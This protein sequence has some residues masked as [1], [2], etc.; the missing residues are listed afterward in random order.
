MTTSRKEPWERLGEIA[1]D[2]WH[3]P[4]MI[5]N[6]VVRSFRENSE[7]MGLSSD[8]RWRIRPDFAKQ[9]RKNSLRKLRCKGASSPCGANFE[10]AEI[11]KRAALGARAQSPLPTQAPSRPRA[12]RMPVASAEAPHDC[13][14]QDRRRRANCAVSH[15]R[16]SGTLTRSYRLHS[17]QATESSHS[18]APRASA[19]E[20]TDAAAQS[21]RAVLETRTGRPDSARACKICRGDNR[22]RRLCRVSQIQTRTASNADIVGEPLSFHQPKSLPM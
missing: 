16:N 15:A 21:T 20:I 2:A 3:A 1:G 10:L 9:E 19:D 17:D 13:P 12:R 22:A 5:P 8:K 7:R 4:K 6:A 18:G 11:V 14:A